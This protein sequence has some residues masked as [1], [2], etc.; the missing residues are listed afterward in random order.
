[1]KFLSHI[2][3]L[4]AGVT[5]SLNGTAGFIPT[6][7][8]GHVL[9]TDIGD[10]NDSALICRSRIPISGGGDWYLHPAEMS[11]DEDDIIS[12]PP[13]QGWLRN[14]ATDSEGHQLVRLRRASATAEEGVFTCHIPG[15]FGTFVGIYYSSES[16]V[17]NFFHSGG[18]LYI[19][20]YIIGDFIP[21]YI[22]SV[23]ISVH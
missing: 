20:T 2:L 10:T 7:G 19:I 13:V 9:I 12:P 15:D 8:G 14:R 22:C 23:S 3:Y 6:D 1:M 17:Y 18:W 5:F 16:Q 11:T 21:L 4:A